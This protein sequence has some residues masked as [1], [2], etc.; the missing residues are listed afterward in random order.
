M[1]MM[2]VMFMMTLKTVMSMVALKT[3][4]SVDSMMFVIQARLS[5]RQKKIL[6]A[7]TI[8]IQLLNLPQALIRSLGP[9]TLIPD[10]VLARVLIDNSEMKEQIFSRDVAFFPGEM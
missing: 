7:S 9:S 3:V 8:F 4:I 6:K 1:S 10:L 5:Y 2:T